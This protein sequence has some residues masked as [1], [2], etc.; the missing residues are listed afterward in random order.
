MSSKS[1]WRKKDRAYQRRRQSFNS[2]RERK[3]HWHRDP[4]EE[5]WAI[6]VLFERAR[7]LQ[8]SSKKIVF[9]TPRYGVKSASGAKKQ[10][11]GTNSFNAIMNSEK[12]FVHEKITRT[13]HEKK[14]YRQNSVDCN[15]QDFFFL[16]FVFSN[17]L[18][19][20]RILCLWVQWIFGSDCKK[21]FFSC[22][23]V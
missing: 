22:P 12:S 3:K 8:R 19:R 4:E 18:P 16:S 9:T 14:S 1:L 5:V 17:S 11:R 23:A 10:V 13:L 20:V 6:S 7:E 15:L 21:L 2:Q